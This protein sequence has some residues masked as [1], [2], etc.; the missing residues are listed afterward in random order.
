LWGSSCLC[1][2]AYALYSTLTRLKPDPPGANSNGSPKSKDRVRELR[3]SQAVN[4]VVAEEARERSANS[5]YQLARSWDDMSISREVS[6]K[7]WLEDA[8]DPMFSPITRL[9]LPTH[10]RARTCTHSSARADAQSL[11]PSMLAHIP[12]GMYPSMLS[13]IPRGPYLNTLA[14]MPKGLY[15]STLA[16]T[17]P[18]AC[19]STL[20]HIPRGMYPST[21]AHVPR[22]MYP[23]TLAHIPRDM[24]LNTLTHT[25]RHVSQHAHTPAYI[26]AQ[27]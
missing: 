15:P 8:G 21:L 9:S 17:Y 7:C 11:V 25:Q 27:M 2:P 22:G 18:E 12:R 1:H 26:D 19:I 4:I 5:E 3:T 24:Y 23:S 13:H 14:C 10:A 16:C 20:S 6:G